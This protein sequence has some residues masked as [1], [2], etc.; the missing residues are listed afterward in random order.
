MI[1]VVGGIWIECFIS[2]NTCFEF[3]K[4]AVWEVRKMKT[5]DNQKLIQCWKNLCISKSLVTETK[6]SEMEH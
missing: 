1:Q 6:K 2:C 3:Y 5:N 4:S